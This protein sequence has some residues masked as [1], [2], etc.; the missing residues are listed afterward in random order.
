MWTTA[1]KPCRSSGRDPPPAGVASRLASKGD[2]RLTWLV[3]CQRAPYLGVASR[4][5]PAISN[6]RRQLRSARALFAA[7]TKRQHIHVHD[8]EKRVFEE[9]SASKR[10]IEL[11]ER[12]ILT[13]VY[14]YYF[15]NHSVPRLPDNC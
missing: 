2:S 12:E 8:V 9:H 6:A 7:N 5:S 14:I 15:E 3:D 4:L 10:S 1:S 11:A 13:L